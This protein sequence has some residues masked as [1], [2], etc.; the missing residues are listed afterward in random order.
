MSMRE[1]KKLIEEKNVTQCCFF[2]LFC[3]N[4]K[5]KMN[6]LSLFSNVVIVWICMS[7]VYLCMC[8]CHMA[9]ES[10][11]HLILFYSFCLVLVSIFFFLWISSRLKTIPAHNF[12]FLCILC[13]CT[14]KMCCCFFCVCVLSSCC[15]HSVPHN[16]RLNTYLITYCSDT[17]YFRQWYKQFDDQKQIKRTKKPYQKKVDNFV[18]FI[19]IYEK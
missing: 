17:L 19:S 5:I 14:A 4:L 1:K 2:L 8:L 7:H 16:L 3:F 9:S 10:V 12:A 13:S 15:L 18:Q 6:S 11:L